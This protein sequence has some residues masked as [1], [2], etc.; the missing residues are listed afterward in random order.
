MKSLWTATAVV[1]LVNFLAMAGG[2]VWLYGTGRLNEDRITRL[3][4]IFA[5]TIAEEEKARQDDEEKKKKEEID[6]REIARLQRVAEGPNELT[7]KIAEDQE[8]DEIAMQRYERLKR[9][10]TDLKRTNELAQRLLA[11]ERA[12]LESER[13]AFQ[14]ILDAEQKKRNDEDFKQAVKMY[15]Q[16]KAKQAKEMFVQ[17]LATNQ[18]GQVLDY[19]AAMQLRK[20]AAVLKEFKTPAEVVQATDIVQRLRQRGVV[21]Q[22]EP[23]SAKPTGGDS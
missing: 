20:A 16:L 19:L 5:P 2:A 18:T 7:A 3:T 14:A 22:P 21:L 11:D 12:K 13:K 23:T 15:E 6:A 1:L 10:I 9:D 17:L 4:A 8:K